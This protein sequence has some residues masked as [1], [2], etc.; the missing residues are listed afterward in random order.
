MARER[1][2]GNV[3]I[4]A[5]IAAAAWALCGGPAAAADWSVTGVQVLHGRG[6]ELGADDREIITFEHAS[7]WKLGS[8]FFF[9]DVSEPF[10]GGT[11]VYGEWYPRLSW[12]ALGITQGGGGLVRDVSFAASINA[13]RDFR[14]YLAGVTLHLKVPRFAYLDLDVMSYDDRTDSDVT[15]IVTPAWEL[16]FTVGRLNCRFRGFVDLIGA[17]GERTRQLLTQPQLLVD[18][19]T[20]WGRKDT[21]FVGIEY[22]YWHNK[23]GLDGVTESLPQ[24]MLLWQL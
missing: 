22:Q 17:E 18:L 1:L 10:A 7:G 20:L 11:D 8:N 2:R 24:L 21:V 14:A 5:L 23:Y 12:T 16:P 4:P 6:F 9:F 3:P 13:G 19:G 15:Y